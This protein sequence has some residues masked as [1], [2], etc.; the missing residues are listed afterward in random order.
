MSCDALKG[1]V[2]DW[3][4]SENERDAAMEAYVQ[5]FTFDEMD[6]HKRTGAMPPERERLHAAIWT[7]RASVDVLHE[8]ARRIE[9]EGAQPIGMASPVLEKDGSG[10]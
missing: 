6:E 5:A 7:R 9:S 8:H 2:L 1:A 3:W 10:T 4:R